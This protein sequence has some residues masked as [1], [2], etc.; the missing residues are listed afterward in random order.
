MNKPVQI[1]QLFRSLKEKG[2]NESAFFIIII[3]FACSLPLFNNFILNRGDVHFHLQRIQN[4][5]VNLLEGNFPVRMNYLAGGVDMRLPKPWCGNIGVPRPIMYPELFLYIPAILCILGVPLVFSANAFSILINLSCALISYFSVKQITKSKN[6]GLIFSG[7]YTLSIYRLDGIFQRYT[8]GE[9][10]AIVFIPLVMLGIYE[11]LYNDDKKWLLLVIGITGVLQSHIISFFISA[12]FLVLFFFFS[13]KHLTKL[14]ILSLGKS[15]VTTLGLNAWFIIPFFCYYKIVDLPD[16]ILFGGV[17]E[18]GVSF[19]QM[20]LT[21]VDNY[22]TIGGVVGIGLVLFIYGIWVNKG[23][24]IGETKEIKSIGKVS[25]LF[26][27]IAAFFASKFFPWSVLK[28]LLYIFQ[29]IQFAWRFFI[30]ATPLLA[31]SA[32]IGFY[33]FFKRFNIHE[34]LA[35]FIAVFICIVGNAYFIDNALKPAFNLRWIDEVWNNCIESDYKYKDSDW[36]Y[37]Q[38]KYNTVVKSSDDIV[39]EKFKKQNDKIALSFINNSNADD[40]YI[41]VP[42]YAFPGYVAFLNGKKIPV[43]NGTNNFIRLYL[44]YGVKNGTIKVSYRESKIFIIG[45][46]ITILTIIVLCGVRVYKTRKY[47]NASHIRLL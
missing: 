35:V 34:K 11:I 23:E 32:S 1:K 33:I 30:I 7:I 45:N 41:E 44:P 10:Q 39:L 43:E 4:I 47:K 31:L 21:F 16:M 17:P 25:L 42:L 19:N 8:L 36:N 6:I 12:C 27:F 29:N 46:V 14:R 3:T 24:D 5:K 20:F 2:F 9:A 18:T 40:S 26:G 22:L 13:I 38:E 28:P 37:S 15:I